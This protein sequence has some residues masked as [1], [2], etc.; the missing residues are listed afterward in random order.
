[1]AN[2][3]VLFLFVFFQEIF[4]AR[5]GHLIDI[6]LH[7]I[8]GHADAVITDGDRF[9]LTINAYGDLPFFPFAAVAGHGSHATLAD[10]ISCV[11]DQ[12]PKKNFMA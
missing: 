12:L 10:G 6:A 11:T 7:L 5:E 8:S 9:L 1:M 3:G 4:R 2:D